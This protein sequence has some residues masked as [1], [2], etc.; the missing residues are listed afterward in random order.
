MDYQGRVKIANLKIGEQV[1]VF[2]SIKKVSA[3]LTLKK[4]TVLNLT[5]GDGTG[6]IT[7]SFFYKLKNRKML[8]R[9]KAQYPV[10]SSVLVFGTVKKDSYTNKITIDKPEVQIMTCDFCY[11]DDELINSG[12]IVPI[13]PLTENLSSKTLTNAIKGAIDKYCAK[14]KDFM[15]QHIKEEY[16]LITKD[17]DIKVK[18]KIGE[19]IGKIF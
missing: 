19:A 14:I 6:E 1:T 13:Y 18:F 8:E 15:P 3:Y 12:K 2:A 16:N 11:E 4:L 7:L 10:G 5:I 17:D 9:Y